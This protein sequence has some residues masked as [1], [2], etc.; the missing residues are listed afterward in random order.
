VLDLE[1][2]AVGPP[3]WD[4]VSTAVRFTTFGTMTFEEYEAFAGAYGHDVVAWDGFEVLRDIRESRV[5][6]Y[7]AQRASED[8][9]LPAEARL[10][11]ACRRGQQGPRPWSGWTPLM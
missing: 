2:F 3:E 8:T 9:S 6:C 5:T 1:R 7:A 10:R 11:M 4:L